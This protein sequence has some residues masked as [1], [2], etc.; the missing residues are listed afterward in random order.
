MGALTRARY[1]ARQFFGALRPGVDA[2]L[3]DEALALL[4]GGERALFESMTLRDRQHCLD[5]FRRLRDDGHDDRD[6]LVAAL[7][8]DAGKGEVALWHRVAFVLLE[9]VPGAVDRVAH[10]G[11]GWRGVMYRCRHHDALG[12][13]L[14]RRAGSSDAVVA[15]IG[16]NGDGEDER[17]R[18]LHAA[19]DAV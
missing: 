12:A 19:D 2:G 5:V 4:V 11:A 17:L 1:R 10:D 9:N 14:A 15:L 18:A 16:A 3:R 8:H 6:L 13:E 7:L